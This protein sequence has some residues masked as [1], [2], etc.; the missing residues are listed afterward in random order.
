[1]ESKENP[2][3]LVITID[4]SESV[5]GTITVHE[6][7][8]PNALS[9]EFLLRY[10]LD[11]SMKKPLITVIKTHQEKFKNQK[12]ISHKK[13]ASQG[14]DQRKTLETSTAERILQNSDRKSKNMSKS[15]SCSKVNYGHLL[16]EKGLKMKE[17]ARTLS[18]QLALEEE[19]VEKKELTFTPKISKNS[20]KLVKG[21][22]GDKKLEKNH[23]HALEL[24]AK[25]EEEEMKECYF[26][27]M[28]SAKSSRIEDSSKNI[29]SSLYADA[30]QRR[31]SQERLKPKNKESALFKTSDKKNLE[32]EEIVERLS[33][34]KPDFELEKIKKET[35]EN[36]DKVS[37]Q[38]LFIPV[39]GRKPFSAR[40]ER[41][42]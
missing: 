2:K 22:R 7:D 5:K 17:H 39:T 1:M 9:E 40:G 14:N 26:V 33:K 41:P 16:Y 13:Y 3:I 38:R 29:F 37:G 32:I 11:K 6:N 21:Q 24:K 28:V 42:V 8:D 10:S 35:D 12:K 20:K 18:E 15:S 25:A 23:E 19:I 30:C 36:Y 4:I 31:K 27:P 34:K